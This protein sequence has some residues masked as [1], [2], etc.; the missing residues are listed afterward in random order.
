VG[1]V[2]AG[3]DAPAD[4]A[5]QRDRVVPVAE[6]VPLEEP[7]TELPVEP[8][9]EPAPRRPVTAPVVVRAVAPTARP[10]AGCGTTGSLTL[11]TTRGV[12]YERTAGDGRTGEWEVTA[13]ARSGYVLRSG[14]RRTFTG[15]LG[16]ATACVRLV[17][18]TSTEDEHPVWASWDIASAV[19]VADTRAHALSLTFDFDQDVVMVRVDEASEGW[20]CHTDDGLP[21]GLQLGMG[22]GLGPGLTGPVVCDVAVTG[23]A[24][25]S[26]VLHAVASEGLL[27]PVEPTGTATLRAD[28]AVV[29][30]SAF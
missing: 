23:A 16:E 15:D 2:R 1:G 6:P 9:A 14:S 19:A 26:L 11:P 13:S 20:T 17:S 3:E 29:G 27:Q 10:V 30:T 4:P 24:P 7:A 12:R 28:G 5:P 18:V 8:E 22:L 21:I 25:P